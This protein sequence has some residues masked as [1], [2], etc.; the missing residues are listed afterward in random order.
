MTVQ[1]PEHVFLRKS[2][3]VDLLETRV[4]TLEERLEAM[5]KARPGRKR[6]PIVAKEDGVCGIDPSRD[7]ATCKDANVYRHQQGC[8]G[9]ACCEANTSYYVQYRAKSKKTPEVEISE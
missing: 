3:G 6:K 5:E 7:S 8:R 4:S 2:L 1:N 9:T